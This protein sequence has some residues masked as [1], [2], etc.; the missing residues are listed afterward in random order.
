[1]FTGPP[2]N[3]RDHVIAGAKSLIQGD[4]RKC[5]D[6][7]LGLD[8]W[9]LIPGTGVGERVKVMLREKIQVKINSLCTSLC[10][11]RIE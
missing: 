2:E 11:H 9:N 3:I 10:L 4:W 6:L 8:V 7:I 1:V 5:A